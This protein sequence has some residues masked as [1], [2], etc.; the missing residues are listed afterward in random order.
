MI[1]PNCKGTMKTERY[2]GVPIN[3]CDGC[4]SVWVG[5]KGLTLITQRREKEIDAQVLEGIDKRPGVK[6][7]PQFERDSERKLACPVCDKDMELANYGYSSGILIDRCPEGCGV[8]LDDQELEAIQA[9]VE[10]NDDKLDELDLY[11]K[12]LASQ[13][14]GKAM[15]SVGGDNRPLGSFIYGLPGALAGLIR[16]IAKRPKS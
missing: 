8:F 7:L 11:Y 16:W 1:C 6:F 13:S 14:A 9:W 15:T 5:Q 4:N 10:V 12:A 3:I 2:E